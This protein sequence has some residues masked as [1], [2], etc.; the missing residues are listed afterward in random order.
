MGSAKQAGSSNL[1]HVCMPEPIGTGRPISKPPAGFTK[2]PAAGKLLAQ[3]TCFFKAWVLFRQA[4]LQ[5]W[6]SEHWKYSQNTSKVRAQVLQYLMVH[7]KSIE[8]N[9]AWLLVIKPRSAVGC[10]MKIVMVL[11]VLKVVMS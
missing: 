7:A 5:P 9:A 10:A 2:G 6:Y 8:V 11:L 4:F 1:C 3:Q